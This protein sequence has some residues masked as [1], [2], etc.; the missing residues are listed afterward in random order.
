VQPCNAA[1]DG[2]AQPPRLECSLSRGGFGPRRPGEHVQNGLRPI[3]QT[4]AR[5]TSPETS[6]GSSEGSTDIIVLDDVSARYMK[7]TTALQTSDVGLGIARRFRSAARK[8][9]AALIRWSARCCSTANFLRM[10]SEGMLRR[11]TR[12]VVCTAPG[13]PAPR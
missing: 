3:E 13:Y 9:D 2:A 1:G 11:K 5:E 4:I 10:K 8:A 12:Q 6:P 7:D